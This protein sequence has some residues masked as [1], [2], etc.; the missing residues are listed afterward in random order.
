MSSLAVAK[1]SDLKG[2]SSLAVAKDS[3]LNGISSLKGDSFV[4]HIGRSAKEN[5]EL[6]EESEPSDIWFHLDN[7]SSPY[8]IIEAIPNQPIIQDM[9][10]K[11]AKLCKSYSKDNKSTRSSVI[12]CPVSNLKKGKEVGSVLLKTK[13]Q[14]ITIYE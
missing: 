7:K 6:L 8:V 9:I 10:I 5:W 4:V 12:Y 14:R 1:D 11:C 2:M 13:P 3:D